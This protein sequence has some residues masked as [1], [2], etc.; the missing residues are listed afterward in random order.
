[1][2][3]KKEL[4]ES[5]INEIDRVLI[6]NKSA[7]VNAVYLANA[8]SYI[9][10]AMSDDTPPFAV[11]EY[12]ARGEYIYRV[13]ETDNIDVYVS[14]FNTFASICFKASWSL[15][16]ITNDKPATAEQIATF[17][18]AKQFAKHGREWSEFKKGD[19]VLN[20]HTDRIGI[21]ESVDDDGDV[22][23]NYNQEGPLSFRDYKCAGALYL[24]LIQ[25]AEEL[26]EVN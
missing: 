16:D 13:E 21:V 17:K 5:A 10:E 25:T 23:V 2:T 9:I 8:K 4:L 18:R 15:D 11:G 19:T 3:E 1:M 12:Y 14:A 20:N 7:E 26:Q 6:G 24:D 22:V